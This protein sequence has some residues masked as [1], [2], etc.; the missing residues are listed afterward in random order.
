MLGVTVALRAKG[1]FPR[2]TPV[3]VA[4]K[5]LL[6][7]LLVWTLLSMF[8]NFDPLWV[9]AAV[10][11]AALPPAL[12]S[13]VFATQYRVGLDRASACILVGTACS[14]FT[15]TA[16]LWLIRAGRMPADLFP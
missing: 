8:G 4:F 7:P 1:G 14:L 9:Y 12:T 5:L 6:H 15:L 11:M 10:L 2:E 13:F 16:L 3:L